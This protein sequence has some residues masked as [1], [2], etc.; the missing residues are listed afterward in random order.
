[1]KIYRLIAVLIAIFLSSNIIYLSGAYDIPVSGHIEVVFSD[2]SKSILPFTVYFKMTFPI[3]SVD[4]VNKYNKTVD[5]KE[6]MVFTYYKQNITVKK[7][8]D[9]IVSTKT[10]L[11][12]EKFLEANESED[13]SSI[14]NE[15]YS[16]S[17]IEIGSLQL[18]DSIILVRNCIKNSEGIKEVKK[19]TLRYENTNVIDGNKTI[20]TRYIMQE[21]NNSFYIQ[22][23]HYNKTGNHYYIM[24]RAMYLSFEYIVK[25]GVVKSTFADKRDINKNFISVDYSLDNYIID[26]LNI[27]IHFQ[28]NTK[29][30]RNGIFQNAHGLSYTING[31]VAPGERTKSTEYYVKVPYADRMKYDWDVNITWTMIG[32]VI[33][34]AIS[35]VIE[36]LM[37]KNKRVLSRNSEISGEKYQ[38]I[39]N[40]GEATTDEKGDLGKEDNKL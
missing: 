34:A 37:K 4:L 26:G 25:N 12:F 21:G 24:D 40:E 32:I 3:I 14:K 10:K 39:T 13:E 9:V 38:N 27:S 23:G 18:R 33:G 8:G 19:I 35:V 17:P 36:E 5:S 31:I 2:G 30:E 22:T 6:N 1:M 11:Y 15:Y 20:P 28:K 7:N 16:S 29:I